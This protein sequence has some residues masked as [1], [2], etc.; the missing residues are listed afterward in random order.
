MNCGTIPTID[1]GA[2]L[3]GV[4]QQS[5]V[6]AEELRPLQDYLVHQYVRR[7]ETEDLGVVREE[8]ERQTAAL[9]IDRLP[10]SG[11]G[12]TCVELRRGVESREI[13][14]DHR[15]SVDPALREAPREARPHDTAAH[16]Q[17]VRPLRHA[18]RLAR[19]ILA[20][21]A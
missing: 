2:P 6:S 12:T 10:P 16:D 15:D 4:A 20:R 17:D 7:A 21:C 1:G 14:V 8:L 9:D 5:R 18:E 11:T 3:G 19:A 13:E